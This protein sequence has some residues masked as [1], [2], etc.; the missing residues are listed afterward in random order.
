MTA[1]LRPATPADAAIIALLGRIT[2]AETFGSLFRE[3]QD[4][5]STY[6]DATFDVTKLER[7]LDKR[8]NSYWLAHRQRLPVGYAKLKHPSPPPRRTEHACQL[9]KIYVLREFLGQRIGCDLMREV[10][11]AAA[12]R[13]PLLWLDVLQENTRAARF[14]E[15]FGFAAAGADTYAIGAQRF[16]FISMQRRTP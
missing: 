16:S 12:E 1:H 8:E 14:Y 7:S 3:R 11:R 6:L 2:F 4:D 9:Q 15:R 10:M 5:L 13:A